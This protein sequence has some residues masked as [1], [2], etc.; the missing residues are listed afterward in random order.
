MFHVGQRVVCVE[1]NEDTRSCGIHKGSHYTIALLDGRFVGIAEARV[2]G[3]WYAWRF[4]SLTDI[5]VFTKLLEGMKDGTNSRTT[6][7]G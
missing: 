2:T 4:R 7:R 3:G 6:A 5:S 1:D